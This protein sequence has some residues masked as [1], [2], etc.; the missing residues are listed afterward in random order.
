MDRGE[1]LSFTLPLDDFLPGEAGE[2]EEEEDVDD[3]F[4]L[5]SGM[6]EGGAEEEEEEEEEDAAAL[7][8]RRKKP[9]PLDM[10]SSSNPRFIDAIF[11]GDKF[12]GISTNFLVL[13]SSDFFALFSTSGL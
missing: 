7:D 3:D 5:S 11:K 10:I 9:P 12:L 8:A 6:F 2:E 1:G 13:P 4:E